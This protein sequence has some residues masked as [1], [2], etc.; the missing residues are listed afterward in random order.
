MRFLVLPMIALGLTAAAPPAQ[1]SA[2]QDPDVPRYHRGMY[3][4]DSLAVVDAVVLGVPRPPKSPPKG[5]ESKAK[6][7]TAAPP[8]NFPS[9][10]PPKPP[11]AT[12]EVVKTLFGSLHEDLHA[13]KDL[14]QLVGPHRCTWDAA[15]LWL[16]LRTP[17]GYFVLN[18]E[19]DPLPAGEWPLL[20]KMLAARPTPR[21]DLKE[22]GASHQVYRY[23]VDQKTGKDVWHG[24]NVWVGLKS[25]YTEW[26]EDG[27]RVLIRGWDDDGRLEIIHRP[28][29][30]IRFLGGRVWE[31]RRHEGERKIGLSRTYYH[32]KLDQRREEAHWQNG[33][34]HGP[35]RQWDI[36]G[37]LLSEVL[38]ETGFVAPVIR[39]RGKEPSRAKL[40]QTQDD[41]WYEADRTLMDALKV[42]LTTAEVSELLRLDFSERDGIYFAEYEPRTSLHITFE[43]GRIAGRD[44]VRRPNFDLR[45]K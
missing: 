6:V 4:L 41:N 15:G 11:A 30:T 42:G 28:G 19:P 25:M 33:R 29:L 9:R 32:E 7:L 10:E 3:L 22:K 34:R 2:P 24:V 44:L 20:S 43:N 45:A 5:A 37:K 23:Y 39:Y 1:T 13:G 40:H 26:F 35:T 16:L 38:Y 36:K 18:P 21:S 27:K 8:P 14:V 12:L 17:Q 31:F